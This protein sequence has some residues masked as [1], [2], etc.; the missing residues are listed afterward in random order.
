MIVVVILTP[1][2]LLP[3]TTAESAQLATLVALAFALIIMFEYGAK[4]PGL[5]E[6]R[7]A[8]PFNRIRVIA[9]FL[10]L[11]GLSIIIGEG[12]EGSALTVMK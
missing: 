8:P 9:L 1:S 6:F 3:G 7:N 5:I 4:Y 10:M 11:F 12:N 2:L